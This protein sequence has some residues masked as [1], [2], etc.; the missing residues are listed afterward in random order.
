MKKIK[1]PI[2]RADLNKGYQIIEITDELA[3][4]QFGK[5]LENRGTQWIGVTLATDADVENW[6][7]KKQKNTEKAFD[8][9][10][11]K[12]KADLLKKVDESLE[13]AE[14]VQKENE[15]LKK[16]LKELEA[17][18]EVKPETKTEVIK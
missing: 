1:K 4:K 7:D 17:K 13:M 12:A 5:P 9:E 3:E 2:D 6:G 14:L 15:E 8:K 16:K 11:E 18:K 10:E